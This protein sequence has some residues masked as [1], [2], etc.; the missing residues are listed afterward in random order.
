MAETDGQEAR[1]SEARTA[2]ILRRAADEEVRGTLVP[3]TG[4]HSLE[5]LVSI[6][7]EAGIDAD[8]VRRS[9]C[10]VP[11]PPDPIQRIF[12][13]TPTMPRVRARFPGELT[14]DR[15]PLARDTVEHTFG[16]H[17]ELHADATGFLWRE[18]HGVGR[19]FVRVRRE[20]D[21][22][23]VEVEADRKGHLFALMV[24]LTTLVALLLQPLGGFVGLAALVGPLLGVALPVAAVLVSTRGLWPLLARPVARKAEAATMALGALVTPQEPPSSDEAE[25]GGS[26]SAKR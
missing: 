22:T 7:R 10:L 11:V 20:G 24:V 2:E 16:R 9:A 3:R 14:G 21:A 15:V 25:S 13:G 23:D 4:G 6:A 8:A 19:T 5:E 1:F 18:D 26:G 12:L 17:G